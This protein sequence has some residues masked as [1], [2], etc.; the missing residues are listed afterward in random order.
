MTIVFNSSYNTLVEML[1]ILCVVGVR[2]LIW[3]RSGSA[4]YSWSVETQSK[5]QCE[6]WR[7]SEAD[8]VSECWLSVTSAASVNPL[9]R[10]DWPFWVKCHVLMI[11]S[12]PF[13]WY[14]HTGVSRMLDV[15]WVNLAKK[16]EIESI[17][18]LS[19]WV[20]FRISKSLL[21]NT[22]C[23]VRG[24]LVLLSKPIDVKDEIA[25]KRT[26]DLHSAQILWL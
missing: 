8:A 2:H 7:R 19:K 14:S 1:W 11:L 10:T 23:G 22:V 18:S 17:Q 24:E 12:E 26:E 20:N 15:D 21:E 9:Q 4:F 5:C 25:R 6:W 13:S 16:L 3:T